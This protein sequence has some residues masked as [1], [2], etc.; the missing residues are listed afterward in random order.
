MNS[1]DVQ[2]SKAA[3]VRVEEK[4]FRLEKEEGKARVSK[5]DSKSS[6]SSSKAVIETAQKAGPW[7]SRG[8]IMHLDRN[9]G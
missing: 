5:L 8:K 1:N 6:S 7:N 3:E 2:C 9:W 4:G